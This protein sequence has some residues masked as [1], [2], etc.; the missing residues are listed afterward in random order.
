MVLASPRIL[1]TRGLYVFLFIAIIFFTTIYFTNPVK[2]SAPAF[3]QLHTSAPAEKKPTEK[4]P[5]EKA[6][7]DTESHDKTIFDNF[8][9]VTGAEHF[10][11]PNIIHFIRFQTFELNFVDYMV[12]LAAMRN[13]K[14]DKFFF[15]TNV[16]DVQFTGKY[17]GLVQQDEDL[18]SRI[19][20]FFLEAP[21][22]IFGQKLN[23]VWRFY[24]GSDIGRI[25]VLMKYGGIYFDNDAYVIRSLDKYRKFEFVI[26]WDENEFIGTQVIIAH[27]DARFLPLWLD[28]YRDYHSDKWYLLIFLLTGG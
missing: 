23:E 16:E 6:P 14:P 19:K 1:K 15:H 7:A 3:G 24:H 5:A 18:W 17:W 12:L 9:N 28:S 2:I 26:N 13:H 11:V 8:D 10:I 20:V 25:H 22:E 4:K 27:K 21:T